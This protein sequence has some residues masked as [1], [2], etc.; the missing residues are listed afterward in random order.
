MRR[1]FK[2][3]LYPTH[4]Q[5]I[6]LNE[7][8][9][10]HRRLYNACL[11]QRN[12]A[13]HDYKLSI[14]YKNQSTWFTKER[15]HNPWFAKLNFSSAQATM[16]RLDKAFQ[17]FFRRVKAGERP[18]YPRFK[19][20]A[21][22][23]SVEF[24]A[25]GDGIKI[26]DERIRT[27]KIGMIKVKWHRAWQGK[28]K[29]VTFKKEAN[30]WYIILSCDLGEA[31]TPVSTN[32]AIGLDVGLKHFVTTSEGEHISNPRFLKQ[33][34]PVLRCAQRAHSRK[35]KRS[36]NR[37]KSAK[38][39]AKMYARVANQRKD[40]SHKLSTNFIRRYGYIAVECLNIRVMM[41][42]RRFARSI[43]DAGWGLFLSHLRYKAE[44][45]GAQV[46]G[47]DPRGTSQECSQCGKVVPKTLDE[48]VHHC[49]H[50]NLVLD[51]DVN[52]AC[53]ILLRALAR[54]GPTGANGRLLTSVA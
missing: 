22:H 51:R 34:L 33:E 14:T 48:R 49:P 43:Q 46:V 40:F 30:R 35:K 7:M 44:N 53:N 42:T 18:G 54:T 39:L 36:K 17:N 41:G 21:L 47:I 25:Y 15:L 27:H 5:A 50:C 38:Q 4:S 9:E 28:I 13:Y 45:A 6:L 52:A 11:A 26:L 24:P 10:T 8:L 1:S 37:K 12:L 32:P 29:T 2:Y 19:A 31:Q 20:Y 16:R 23:H 3:R